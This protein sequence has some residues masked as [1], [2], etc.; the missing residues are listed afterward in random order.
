MAQKIRREEMVVLVTLG[1]MVLLAAGLYGAKSFMERVKQ[2][3]AAP[4]DHPRS[5]ARVGTP[6]SASPT[7]APSAAA[8]FEP[9]ET[10]LEEPFF[11]E[12]RITPDQ[13]DRMETIRAKGQ[14]QTPQERRERLRELREV[15]TEEQRDRMDAR[16]ADRIRERVR[17]R[18]ERA[19]KEL[20]AEQYKAFEDDLYRRFERKTP[21]PQA[22][23]A[24]PKPVHPNGSAPVPGVQ[25]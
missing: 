17:E 24:A 8:L 7:S 14:P 1:S 22:P 18:L 23:L 2:S 11:E 20:S 25:E 13:A 3:S 16:T 10:P 9:E 19:R 4:S 5:R 15:L 21:P 6:H 12:I